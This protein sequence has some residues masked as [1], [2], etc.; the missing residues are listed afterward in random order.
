[1]AEAAKQKLTWGQLIQKT[2]FLTL[3][4]FIAGFALDCFLVPN[5]IIDVTI[6]LGI[7]ELKVSD[8]ADDLLKEADKA[9]YQ[10]KE[11]GRNRIIIKTDE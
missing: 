4:A 7:Y 11:T 10:A 3:G 8:S 6:S 9:L 5:K 2:F 1:M